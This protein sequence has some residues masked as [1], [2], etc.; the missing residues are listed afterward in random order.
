MDIYIIHIKRYVKFQNEV[1]SGAMSEPN[2]MDSEI[3]QQL[4]LHT[5]PATHF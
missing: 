5:A 3:V 4:K 2:G 1:L